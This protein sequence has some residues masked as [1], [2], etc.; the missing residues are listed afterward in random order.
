MPIAYFTLMHYIN[1]RTFIL[2]ISTLQLQS[3]YATLMG[4]FIDE[5]GLKGQTD[6]HQFSFPHLLRKRISGDRI[7]N[8]PF[9]TA[10]LTQPETSK[11]TVSYNSTSYYPLF[12]HHQTPNERGIT[13]Q[14][15]RYL[16]D[17]SYSTSV[18]S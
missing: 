13:P 12:I 15:T 18:F 11:E 9:H 2:N 3:S 1:I 7:F 5:R 8:R 16:H 6:P 14:R 4:C 17:L 10:P